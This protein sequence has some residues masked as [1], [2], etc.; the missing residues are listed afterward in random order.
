MGTVG[1]RANVAESDDTGMPQG[2]RPRPGLAGALGL[3]AASAVLWGVAHLYMRRHVAGALLMSGYLALAAALG[4][5][6][7]DHKGDLATLAVQS[8]W[9]TGFTVGVLVLA[10]A[11]IGVVAWSYRITRP[12]ELDTAPRVAGV[13]AVVVLC[14]AVC[15]PLVY[16]AQIS[17]TTRSTLGAIFP[18]GGD[19]P[20][21]NADDPFNGHT[22][23]NIALLASDNAWDRTGTRTD[24]MTVA[25]IDTRTGDTVLLGIP[26]N[27][28]HFQ[29]PP[30]PARDRF[31][32]GF[33]GDG[34]LN[35]GLLNEVFDYAENHPEIVPGVPAGRRGPTL[36]TQTISGII[37]QHIDYYI[38]VD[39]FGFADIVD[40]MGGLRMKIV[41]PIPYGREGGV[42]LPGDQVLNGHEALWYG[43]SRNGT[44][45]YVRM[46]R[47]KCLLRALARQADPEK[48][49]TKFES[50]ATA[51]KR[52]IATNI[53]QGLLPALVK[54]SAKAKGGAKITNLSFVPPLISTG[55]PDFALIQGLTAKAMGATPTA[56]PSPLDTSSDGSLG[57]LSA[58]SSPSPSDSSSSPAAGSSTGSGAAGSAAPTDGAST[59]PS[60]RYDGVDTSGSAAQGQSKPV[61]LDT[62]CPS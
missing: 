20:Q 52:A 59:A 53:P 45:D 19:A 12:A 10:L 50:L 18:S 61:S 62:T 21:I 3:T 36:V 49:L 39:M 7:R 42:L 24:S 58:S 23:V 5:L 26:R 25:S 11:W 43:R 56:S 57:G 15:A 16:A 60:N 38:L 8:S 13:M 47:Q 22:R 34:P 46:G 1:V 14:A 55:N 48:I 4:I 29:M 41:E 28:E 51:T 9:L 30:G 27:L 6:V 37:G 33:T 31:P 40:A 32:Y 54:L 35:P 2:G 44:D 17:N